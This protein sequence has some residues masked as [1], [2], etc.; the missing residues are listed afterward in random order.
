MSEQEL[1]EMYQRLKKAR[2]DGLSL[3]LEGKRGQVSLS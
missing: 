2:E 3:P 1:D